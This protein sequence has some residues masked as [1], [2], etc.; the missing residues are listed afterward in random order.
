ME[1]AVLACGHATT[2][3]RENCATCLVRFNLLEKKRALDD[4]EVQIDIRQAMVEFREQLLRADLPPFRTTCPRVANQAAAKWREAITAVEDAQVAGGSEA[5]AEARRCLEG[6]C[7]K[8]AADALMAVV[9]QYRE[10]PDEDGKSVAR[11]VRDL[12]VMRCRTQAPPGAQGAFIEAV[13]EAFARPLL[14]HLRALI[15]LVY[16]KV[17]KHKPDTFSSNSQHRRRSKPRGPRGRE[18]EGGGG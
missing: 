3:L 17:A 2:D 18:G 12:L 7:T 4:L 10:K 15:L 6:S 11:A 14:T 5:L 1:G 13:E 16:H 8:S 9:E